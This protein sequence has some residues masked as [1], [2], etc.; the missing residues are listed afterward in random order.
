MTGIA[1]EHFCLFGC[2]LQ[3]CKGKQN[4]YTRNKRPSILFS[5]R[6]RN[7]PT[8]SKLYFETHCSTFS[9]SMWCSDKLNLF[10]N[11]REWTDI[12]PFIFGSVGS[13]YLVGVVQ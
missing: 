7:S 8:V 11:P 1:A 3:L 13:P 12:T 4:F 2:H 6:N 9:T 5:D 10:C